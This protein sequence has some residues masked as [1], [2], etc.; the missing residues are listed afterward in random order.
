MRTKQSVVLSFR[1]D[2]HLQG[3]IENTPEE[4]TLQNIVEAGLLSLAKNGDLLTNAIR[5][6]EDKITYYSN[7]LEELK[8][9]QEANSLK[10]QKKEQKTPIKPRATNPVMTKDGRMFWVPDYL[11]D[12]NTDKL[13]VIHE[14]PDGSGD[15]PEAYSLEEMGL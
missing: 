3:L 13:V 7:R 15:W 14:V 10:K 4:V 8:Q 9:I 2:K 11:L 6:T 12:E 5:F 1:P